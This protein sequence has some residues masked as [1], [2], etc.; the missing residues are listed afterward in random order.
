MKTTRPENRPA[1]PRA[2]APVAQTSPA[3]EPPGRLDDHLPRDVGLLERRY[4]M[5]KRTDGQGYAVF[6]ASQTLIHSNAQ[7]ARLY[8]LDPTEIRPGQTLR[9]I[10]ALR[11]EKGVYGAAGAAAYRRE[12]LRNVKRRRVRIQDLNDG[13]SLMIVQ[14]PTHDG[15]W[16]STHE[17]ITERLREEAEVT[18]HAIRDPLTGLINRAALMADLVAA[19]EALRGPEHVCVLML[20]LDRFKPINDTY[21]HETGDEVLRIIAERIRSQV[22]DTDTVARLGGDEFVVLQ[23]PIRDRSRL[24]DRLSRLCHALQ[25][26][27]RTRAARVQVGA[28]IGVA[29]VPADGTSAEEALRRADAALYAAKE[30]GRGGFRIDTPTQTVQTP[31]K[32]PRN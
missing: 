4:A 15:C 1:I 29:L 13:R 24:P 23:S 10:L 27:I 32:R 16:L 6:D 25:E 9:E 11:I 31:P 28:T 21:G 2:N 5:A 3:T 12:W 17:D 8:Q 20:D 7:Y 14:Q 18:F 26:P 22:R 19:L 30:A